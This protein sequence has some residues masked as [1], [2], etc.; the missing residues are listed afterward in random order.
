MIKSF[1]QHTSKYLSVVSPNARKYG[2]E[3]T[4]H[5][6]TFHALTRSRIMSSPDETN[7]TYLQSARK[8]NLH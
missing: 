5:L 4:P 2:P 1:R 6:D 3:I 7:E 8:N